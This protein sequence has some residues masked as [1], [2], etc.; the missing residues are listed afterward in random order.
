MEQRAAS[1]GTRDTHRVAN[2]HVVIV[3]AVP[4]SDLVE[5]DAEIVHCLIRDA[6]KLCF[7]QR[8]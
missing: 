3:C 1:S 5:E 6:V 4:L 2:V 7:A 8:R